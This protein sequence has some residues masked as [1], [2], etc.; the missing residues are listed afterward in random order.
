[1]TRTFFQLLGA[2]GGFNPDR[3]LTFQLPLPASKYVGQNHI[4]AFYENALAQLRSIPGVQAAGIGE[5]VPMGGE[6]ES[7]VIRMPDHPVISQQELPFANYTIISAGYLS[8][9]GTPVLRGRDFLES[10]TA[11]SVPVA[12]VNLA[13]EKKFWPGQGA[14][15]KQVG[16]G[17]ANFPLLTIVG[18]VPDIKHISL[19]EETTPEMY[20]MY[21]QKP[22]PAML[23]LH[24]ALR[25]KA[26]PAAL[27][28]TVRETIH[29]L[30]PELP[31]AR[32]AT[33][34]TLVDD[35]LK[36]P[37]FAM[38]LMA[39]FG[40]LALLLASV[41]MYGV[42][43]YSVQQRTQEIGIRMA[44]GAERSN[45]FRMVLGQGARLA[46]I[47]IA[48]GV[49]AAVGITR[50]MSSFLYGIRSTDPFTFG[51][52]SLLLLATTLLACYLPAHRAMR[53]DPMIALRHE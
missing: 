20:V 26:D 23:N 2:N 39:S 44:L 49:L 50:F 18:V 22:W 16:P 1:L 52:V 14:L 29:S 5:T 41:G 35:S 11:D 46:G 25:T 17:S 15:G 21:T 38:F 28:A 8:S 31:L 45:V 48:L 10:D 12:I 40:A 42:I 4:V 34:T 27:T 51:A 30:D 37:R 19:R 36:Q 53:V 7:T 6:G 47:G 13:M 32:I 43:S 3:V 24:I 9:I 33:L